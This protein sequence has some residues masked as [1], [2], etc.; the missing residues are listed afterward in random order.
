[1]A[2]PRR[3]RP[4]FAPGYGIAAVPDGMLGWD[5]ATE[6]LASARNYWIATT[7]PGN[8]PHAAPVWGLW[9]DDAVVFSTSRE[10]RKG[11]NLVR[12]PRVVIHL[13]SGDEVVIV[14]GEVEE[15]TLDDRLAD[16][17]EAK[18]GYRPGPGSSDGLWLRLRPRVALAWMESDYPST[19][20]RF[21]FD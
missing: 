13:E 11:R 8:A 1:M 21:A 10:S 6:R 16:A 17:Y 20:T 4:R 3:S 12:D 5:W 2:D 18:Y 19:A 14:Q 9:I 7:S 15:T